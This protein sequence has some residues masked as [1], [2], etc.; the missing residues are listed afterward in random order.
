[1]GALDDSTWARLSSCRQG[2]SLWTGLP[3]I[4]SCCHF[5]SSFR[6]WGV[7]G[8]ETP[9]RG[10]MGGP[11]CLLCFLSL[12]SPWSC[13]PRSGKMSARPKAA[14]E[15]LCVGWVG[16]TQFPCPELR[17]PDRPGPILARRSGGRKQA[18]G[19]SPAYLPSPGPRGAARPT[20]AHR[21]V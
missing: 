1:M 14:A 2:L 18:G 21:P 20:A 16:A 8:E 5:I 6:Q 11:R 15:V 12:F 13:A 4:R 3:K 9:S 10:R 19:C 17:S 7:V